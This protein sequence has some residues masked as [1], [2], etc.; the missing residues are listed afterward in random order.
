MSQCIYEH[1]HF[2]MV[3][4]PNDSF[5]MWQGLVGPYYTPYVDEN[6]NLSWTNNGGLPNPATQS[7]KG[8]AGQGVEI[9]GHV[10]TA[11]LLPPTANQGEMWAVG[12]EEPFEAY[13]YL[14]TWI[15]MGLI[16]PRGPKGDPGPIGLTP[17][18]T[19]GTVQTGAPGSQAEATITGTPENPVLNLKIPKGEKG[20]AATTVADILDTDTGKVYQVSQSIVNGYLI[21]TF[22]E[23]TT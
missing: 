13:C 12:E 7:I 3:E 14:G 22:E 11:G 10:N 9:S 15:N 4:D 18:L 16:F 21:E 6:G 23:V 2:V 20:D 5:R 17:N 19:I 8:P 1:D